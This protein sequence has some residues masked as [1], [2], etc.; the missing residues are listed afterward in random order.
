MARAVQNVHQICGYNL[1]EN[2]ENSGSSG[3][4]GKE[5]KPPQWGG[6]KGEKKY[7][8]HAKYAESVDTIRLRLM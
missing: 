5:R 3:E 8:I 7:M 1:I 2:G 4:K 6:N